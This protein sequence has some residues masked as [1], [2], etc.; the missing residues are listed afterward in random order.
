[1]HVANTAIEAQIMTE[2]RSS[3]SCYFCED[4]KYLCFLCARVRK[5]RTFRRIRHTVRPRLGVEYQTVVLPLVWTQATV[6]APAAR[7]GL[8]SPYAVI[9]ADRLAR[10]R[11]TYSNA[12]SPVSKL[13]WVIASSPE[14]SA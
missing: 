1:M 4:P 6:A 12:R 3:V 8:G 2:N 13:R 14:A 7:Y 5:S 9:R 11:A 10:V